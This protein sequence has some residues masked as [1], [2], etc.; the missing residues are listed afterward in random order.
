M[1]NALQA[2]VLCKATHE[3]MHDDDDNDKDDRAYGKNEMPKKSVVRGMFVEAEAQ[4]WKASNLTSWTLTLNL[5][6]TI[7]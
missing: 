2:L 7:N 3:G 5:A 1:C 6:S 4:I